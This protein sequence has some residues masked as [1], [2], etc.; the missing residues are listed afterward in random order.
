MSLNRNNIFLKG[1]FRLFS[2]YRTKETVQRKQDEESNKQ[3][4][5][6]QQ[7]INIK[8][9]K[10]QKIYRSLFENDGRIRKKAKKY[11]YNTEL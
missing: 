2:L 8:L 10:S 7:N 6:Q 4:N 1:N 9:T 11:I 5:E 3:R